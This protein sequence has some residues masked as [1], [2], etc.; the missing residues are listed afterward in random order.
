MGV[1]NEMTGGFLAAPGSARQ[2]VLSELESVVQMLPIEQGEKAE[3]FFSETGDLRFSASQHACTETHSRWSC[4]HDIVRVGV[5]GTG[6]Q[7][8]AGAAE[9]AP[10][11]AVVDRTEIVTCSAPL[12]SDTRGQ[13]RSSRSTHRFRAR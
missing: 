4:S 1:T 6:A 10:R 2:D 12:V 13:V 8:A 9:R 5:A 11:R 7:G 3:T